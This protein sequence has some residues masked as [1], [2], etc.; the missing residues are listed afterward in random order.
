MAG[1]AHFVYPVHLSNTFLFTPSLASALY[2]MLLFFYARRY[3][4]VRAE[5]SGRT[6]PQRVPNKGSGLFT[7]HVEGRLSLLVP[8]TL[9][10]LATLWRGGHTLV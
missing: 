10:L 1:A 9:C 5:S 8:W 3:Q 4:E 2:L 6:N 7:S